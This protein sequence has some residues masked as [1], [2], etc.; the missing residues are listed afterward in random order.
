MERSQF[1]IADF[2]LRIYKTVA[3][4]EQE[5]EELRAKS[6][7]PI[8]KF[9]FRIAPE[10]RNLATKS[11]KSFQSEISESFVSFAIFV[12]RKSFVKC[13]I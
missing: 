6:K 1:R 5:R 11:A 13:C 8:A 7:E 10:E 3:S 2:G 4:W 9:E 12:V